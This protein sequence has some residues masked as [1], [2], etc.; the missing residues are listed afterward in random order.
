[1]VQSAKQQY[2]SNLATHL[3]YD[4]R[5][6]W[7]FQRLSSHQ[8]AQT[9]IVDTSCDAINQHFLTIAQKTVADL[10]SSSVPPLSYIDC[11]HGCA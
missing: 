9:T 4:S 11:M 8:K 3:S 2:F 7:S 5:K 6:F 1:M 10:P